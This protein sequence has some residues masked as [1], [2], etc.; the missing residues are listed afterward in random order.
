M[1]ITKE[2]FDQYEE[3]RQS[4]ETNM[5]DIKRVEML[6]DFELER[7]II[8]NIMSNYEQLQKDFKPEED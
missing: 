5:L 1:L 6:S 2:Q 8:L 3:I 4:G 7:E